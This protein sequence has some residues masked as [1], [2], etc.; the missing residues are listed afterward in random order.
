MF[1]AYVRQ[2]CIPISRPDPV[3]TTPVPTTPVQCTCLA[4]TPGVIAKTAIDIMPG[5]NEG[6]IEFSACDLT[7]QNF[8]YKVNDQ[9]VYITFAAAMTIYN[10]SESTISNACFFEPYSCQFGSGLPFATDALKASNAVIVTAN[11]APSGA[12]YDIYTFNRSDVIVKSEVVVEFEELGSNV[13]KAT[14]ELSDPLPVG[15]CF[16]LRQQPGL[17]Q[18]RV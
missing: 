15:T 2:I 18:G 5:R 16:Y 6:N 3:P 12:S 11:V 4:N 7:P 13:Y 14:F 1:P 9:T 8:W 17:L 10:P